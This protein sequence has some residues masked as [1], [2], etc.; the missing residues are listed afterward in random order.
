MSSNLFEAFLSTPAM[1]DTFGERAVV[2]AMLDFEAALAQAEADEGVIP[3]AAAQAIERACRAEHIDIAALAQAGSRAG[4]LAIPL[5]KQLTARVAQHD[6]EAATW[7]HWGSTSQDV[8][9]SAMVLVTRRALALVDADLQA[10]IGALLALAEREGDAPLLARTLMQPASVISLG[11]KI[12]GW[13]APLLRCRQRLRVAAHEALQIQCGG[14]VGTLATLDDKG[15]AV[16]RRAAALLGLRAPPDDH[17]AAW[18]TQRDTWVALGCEVALLVGVCAKFAR[19]LSLLAQAEVAELNEPGGAG[20]GGSSAMPHKRNPVASMLALAAAQR[21]PQRAAALLA[22]MV[23]EHERGLGNWQAEQAE[24]AG[25]WTSAHGAVAALAEAAAGLQVDRARMR[26]NIDAL[27]GLVFAEA[28]ASRLAAVI[29]K[30]RAQALL[31]TLSRTAVEQGQPLQTLLTQAI[32]A[33]AA[34]AAAVPPTDIERLF[35][36]VAAAGIA[37]DRATPWLAALR[38]QHA[39]TP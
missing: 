19:D 17:Y 28:C 24:W 18:H 13:L 14:A 37:I 30:P 32:A 7:V 15:P 31:E 23:Q 2:Q 21:T 39:L 27:Q 8:I 1:L 16:A 12:A 9:D 38:G 33:D 11:F 34:L 10:L 5:V 25:L 36:P 4:S 26:A 35:D 29:G 6:P 20:R 22:A 3:A